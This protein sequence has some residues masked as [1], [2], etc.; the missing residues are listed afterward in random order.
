MKQQ[1]F[2]DIEYSHRR[3]KTKREEFLEAMDQII[4]WQH[5]IDLIKDYY[6]SGKRGRPP[7]GIETMLRMYLMQNW[8]NLSDAAIEDAIYDSY[9]MRSFMHIDFFT[10]QVPD[11]T[12]LLK[13][14]HLLEVHKI[15][16]QI[17]AD[18]NA[19][20]ESAGLNMHGG[21]IVD[22]T[23]IA[24]PSSTKNKEGKRDEEMHQTKKGNQWYFGMKVHAG[25]DAGSGYVHTITGTAASVHDVNE[26]EKLIREDDEVLYGDSGYLNAAE[27]MKSIDADRLKS[28]DYRF[29]VRP[30]SIKM[31]EAYKGI[32]WDEDIENRK[33]STRCKVEHPFLIVKRQFGYCKTA[34]KGLAKN[35]NRF[36]VLFAC[37]NLV[38]C[39]R[40]GRAEAFCMG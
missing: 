4:P 11:S 10:E 12:T 35:M 38:M 17:F 29:N 16:E 15:G 2:S 40:A 32:R 19:R 22:A 37:A 26:T 34:Y 25:V 30:S 31:S 9:A 5:W 21:T 20:L 3:K 24:A 39:I 36:N 33:S 7:R 23:I 13:F 14:R 28:I 18:V 6:P 27:H 8:F 1:T